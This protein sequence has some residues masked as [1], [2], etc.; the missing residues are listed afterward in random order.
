MRHDPVRIGSQR[1]SP[2][3]QMSRRRR[4]KR[5][6]EGLNVHHVRPSSRGGGGYRNLVLL[7]VEFHANWHKLFVNL[8]VAETHEFIDA[9]MRPDTSWTYHDIDQLRQR[10]MNR[11]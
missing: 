4:Q 2:E 10:I 11:R 7:P 8:T 3:G 1:H 9:L 5:H 6:M